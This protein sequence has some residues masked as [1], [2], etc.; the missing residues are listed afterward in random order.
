[1][2]NEQNFTTLTNVKNSKQM[3]MCLKTKV[4]LDFDILPL[5]WLTF[6]MSKT[7]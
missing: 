7:C 3:K 6:H 1:M 5:T 2:V 4:R